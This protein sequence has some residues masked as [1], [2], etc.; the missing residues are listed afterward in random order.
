MLCSFIS[1]FSSPYSSHVDGDDASHGRGKRE[2]APD[3]TE[4][5]VYSKKSRHD[6]ADDK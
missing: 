5:V 3:V 4:E 6:A 1:V 2:A